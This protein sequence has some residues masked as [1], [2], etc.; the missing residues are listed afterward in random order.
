ML[1]KGPEYFPP[2]PKR[3]SVVSEDWLPCRL[4]GLALAH[5]VDR[6]VERATRTRCESF[7]RD[8]LLE[9]GSV[10]SMRISE[11]SAIALWRNPD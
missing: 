5:V 3:A 9:E 8:Y 11:E 4:R 2:S 1:A 7:G 6:A 10:D